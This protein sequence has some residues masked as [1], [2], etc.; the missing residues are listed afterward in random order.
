MNKKEI[1]ILLAIIFIFLGIGIIYYTKDY[2][3]KKNEKEYVPYYLK[4]PEELNNIEP[5]VYGANEY[6][7]VNIENKA[8]ASIYLKD[9]YNLMKEDINKAYQLLED[10]F[11]EENYKT[12]ESF[13]V[14]AQ[15]VLTNE[16]SL[17]I[18]TKTFSSSQNIDTYDIITESGINYFFTAEA[19]MVYRVRF[20]NK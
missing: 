17:N 2:Y 8:L 11:R 13:Q 7:I 18:V 19:I 3:T 5:K 10:D 4:R 16:N 15:E 12:L 20:E 9:F 6:S 14:F 1:K